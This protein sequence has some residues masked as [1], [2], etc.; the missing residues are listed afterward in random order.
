MVGDGFHL[1]SLD[2]RGVNK[3]RPAARCYP[4]KA[5]RRRKFRP[6]DPD[7]YSR[8]KERLAWTKNYVQACAD[9]MGE[10]GRYINTPQTA[11]D[12][13]S[14]LDAVGQHEML[15]WGFS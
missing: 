6:S 1:L 8:S 10:H 4:N 7:P 9:N 2:P 12:M 14:I 5:V 13:N 15:F 11:A 3:S